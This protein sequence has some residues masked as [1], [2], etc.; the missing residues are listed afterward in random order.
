MESICIH[1]D[2]TG[3]FDLN[4]L[5]GIDCTTSKLDLQAH[6]VPNFMA[7][8][9]ACQGLPA[10][11]GVLSTAL[12]GPVLRPSILT[13]AFDKKKK[14]SKKSV[15]REFVT[16]SDRTPPAAA[17]GMGFLLNITQLPHVT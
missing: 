15:L 17:L 6:S 14:K 2:S 9:K 1:P 10:P 3:H 5:A 7:Q 16:T 13:A 12:K 8:E 11:G 4:S